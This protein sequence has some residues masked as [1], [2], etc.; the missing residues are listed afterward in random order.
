MSDDED[1]PTVAFGLSLV[2]GLL[3][4]IGGAFL[5]I[6]GSAASSVGLYA[7]GGLL[8]GLGFLG[9]LFGVILIV[10]AVQLYRN[11]E[12]H[13]PYGIGILLLSLVSIFTG[14]GFILGLILGVIGGILAI[15]FVPSDDALLLP[16][17]MFTPTT[18]RCANCGASFS[19]ELS[20]CP[21]C[22]APY[23]RWATPS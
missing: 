6:V 5:M 15:L 14:G 20:A 13:T 12:L 19:G 21:S 2:A 18:R 3:V 23:S 8:G 4:F 1:H 9:V 17:D 7:A 11:P 10:L 16:S 22:G